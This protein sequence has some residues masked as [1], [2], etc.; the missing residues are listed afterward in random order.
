MYAG[1]GVM[2][3]AVIAKVTRTDENI[4]VDINADEFWG[5][6]KFQLIFDG[7]CEVESK[8]PVG[9]LLYGLWQDGK[10]QPYRYNFLPEEDDDLALLRVT[11]LGL[12]YDDPPYTMEENY[13]RHF[14]LV[15]FQPDSTQP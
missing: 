11:A 2:H 7:V 4:I 15:G 13:Q 8:N 1:P 12:Q 3:D 10:S 9:L 5:G 6:R 14:H